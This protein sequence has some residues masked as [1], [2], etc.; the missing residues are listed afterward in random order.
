[1]SSNH[2]PP[3]PYQLESPLDHPVMTHVAH[4]CSVD[5]GPVKI[6][7][8]LS[9][10][11]KE[12]FISTKFSKFSEV[13]QLILFL[14]VLSRK[15]ACCFGQGVG[16]VTPAHNLSRIR[17]RTDTKALLLLLLHLLSHR[18]TEYTLLTL[19]TMF[20]RSFHPSPQEEKPCEPATF[21]VELTE[22]TA[23]DLEATPYEPD[24]PLPVDDLPDDQ[25]RGSA[26]CVHVNID[27]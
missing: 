23:L 21:E 16:M 25:V 5:L 6:V 10:F 20:G 17:E 2:L 18:T 4:F 14:A 1:M 15:K 11:S 9:K 26:P 27:I 8:K 12:T 19:G 22:E 24:T 3:A 7:Q 13:Y